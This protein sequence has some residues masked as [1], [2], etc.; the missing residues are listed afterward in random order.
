MQKRILRKNTRGRMGGSEGE[1]ENERALRIATS[2]LLVPD[3]HAHKDTYTATH[4]TQFT[5]YQ[6][7]H[8]GPSPALEREPCE[9]VCVKKN[10]ELSTA[11][12][13]LVGS[14]DARSLD[15]HLL[16]KTPTHHMTASSLYRDLLLLLL[17]RSALWPS[18]RPATPPRHAMS[19]R[20][21]GRHLL[22]AS[23]CGPCGS[24]LRIRSSLKALAHGTL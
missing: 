23:R 11:A 14:A 7:L 24:A 17:P 5:L 1:N 2:L 18:C 15:E 6:Y 12:G 13:K 10:V 22:F 21:R 3:H 19:F 16:Q 20:N 4:T 9:C 8:A